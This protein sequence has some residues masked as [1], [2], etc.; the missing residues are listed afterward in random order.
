MTIWYIY[1]DELSG[2]FNYCRANKPNETK[3]RWDIIEEVQM[4][5]KEVEEYINRFPKF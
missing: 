5:N 4:T 1:W 3:Y 2:Q